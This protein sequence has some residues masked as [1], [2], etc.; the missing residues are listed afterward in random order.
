[1]HFKICPLH[2]LHHFLMRHF[3]TERHIRPIKNIY[4]G[5]MQLKFPSILNMLSTMDK[6][7]FWTEGLKVMNEH[8]TVVHH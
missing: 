7:C 1:M 4:C 2:D 8:H 6:S 3:K 5:A